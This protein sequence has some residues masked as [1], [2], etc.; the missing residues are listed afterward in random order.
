MAKRST[1]LPRTDRDLQ[2]RFG[3]VVRIYRKRLGL[4]QEEL[5]W[6]ADMHRTYLADVERGGR[7]ISLSSIV[8]L[9]KA[10]GISLAE[11][12][13]TLQDYFASPVE[14]PPPSKKTD[15][16]G[17]NHNQKHR[18]TRPASTASRR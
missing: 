5:A 3:A 9:V 2:N 17:R 16:A 18:R 13:C 7:N 4:S 14:T 8:R 6:R 15:A 11:F 12:F 1:L 10:L